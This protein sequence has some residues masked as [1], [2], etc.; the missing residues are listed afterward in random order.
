MEC[1]QQCKLCNRLLFW[2]AVVIS[3]RIIDGYQCQLYY[4]HSSDYTGT[5]YGPFD[6]GQ[7]VYPALNIP[8]MTLLSMKLYSA[9]YHCYADLSISF[10]CDGGTRITVS[11][12]PF[13]VGSYSTYGEPQQLFCLNV[14][15]VATSKPTSSPSAA[16]SPPSISP[17]SSCL[18]Y[19]NE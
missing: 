6:V 9:G 10:S 15:A 19:N 3:T 14:R 12:P 18:D 1:E 5:Q 11:S 7:W 13:G 17:T 16:T 8:K 2:I 4:W